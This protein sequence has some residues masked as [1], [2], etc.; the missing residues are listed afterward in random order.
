MALL[1]GNNNLER[2]SELER[3]RM[4]LWDKFITIRS[5]RQL[6][7]PFEKVWYD[8]LFRH[9]VKETPLILAYENTCH[10]LDQNLGEYKM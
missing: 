6:K 9:F 5:E 8:F 10:D 3:F 4:M 2:N 7:T 1:D